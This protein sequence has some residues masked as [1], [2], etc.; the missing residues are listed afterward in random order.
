MRRFF[1]W[2]ALA[3]LIGLLL[4]AAGYGVYW[5]G[6]A[7]L[8]PVTIA[9]DADEVQQLLERSSWVSDGG[10]GAPVYI[11][12]FHAS[13]GMRRYLREEV[14]RL[15]AAGAEPR[16]VLFAQ[17]DEGQR[18]RSS[19]AERATVAELWLTRDWRLFERWSAASS[20]TWTAA[21]LP[22][23]DASL[24]RSAVVRAGQDFA[25]TLSRRLS[26]SG[27]QAA[28]PLIIWRDPTGDL[29]ACAC[30]DSRSWSFI[31]KDLGTSDLIVPLPDVETPAPGPAPAPLP[32]PK[33][34]AAQP[35][36]KPAADPPLAR[37]GGSGLSA[38]GTL[39]SS[40]AEAQP[41]GAARRPVVR[42]ARPVPPSVERQRPPRSSP[43]PPQARQD[44]ETL[45]Y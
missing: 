4:S 28:Y 32:Y 20:H 23:A 25:Q 19:A 11:V 41:Q 10:P 17:A 6:F 27:L 43:P 31:R 18:S 21:G 2:S 37:R 44:E 5:Y 33:L 26:A 45:F 8:Q 24:A 7:R 40:A 39:P 38:E 1:I 22:S 15:R 34:P 9:G 13:D 42:P 14:P 30:S 35:S 12:G 29:K 36:S 3:A 16:I